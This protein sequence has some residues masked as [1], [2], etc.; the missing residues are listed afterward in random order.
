[1]YSF[2]IALEFPLNWLRYLCKVYSYWFHGLIDVFSVDRISL[3]YCSVSPMFDPIEVS[4]WMGI[5]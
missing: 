5:C 2:P 3:I 1:M 4:E